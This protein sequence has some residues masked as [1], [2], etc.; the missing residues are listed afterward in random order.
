MNKIARELGLPGHGEPEGHARSHG[1]P[2]ATSGPRRRRRG[3]GGRRDRAV[4]RA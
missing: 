1:R 2:A 4:N 3:G